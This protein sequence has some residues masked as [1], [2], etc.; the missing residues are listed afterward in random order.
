MNPKEPWWRRNLMEEELRVVFW[1]WLTVMFGCVMVL[2]SVYFAAS[3]SGFLKNTPIA[4]ELKIES[5]EG[6][7]CL[8]LLGLVFGGLGIYALIQG[9]RPEPKP[10]DRA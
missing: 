2:G 6:I 1:G 4:S 10:M 9:K 5:W 3:Y 8:L 7:V